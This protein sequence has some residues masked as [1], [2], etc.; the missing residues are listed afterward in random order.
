MTPDNL[1]LPPGTSMM[2]YGSRIIMALN[3]EGR[4]GRHVVCLGQTL[5]GDSILEREQSVANA[6]AL[7][8]NAVGFE[9]IDDIV[10]SGEWPGED[11]DNSS[12]DLPDD[13]WNRTTAE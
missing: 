11:G 5:E 13:G 2:I 12:T 10:H 7:F 9:V 8:R 6:A 4:A 1:D 3:W